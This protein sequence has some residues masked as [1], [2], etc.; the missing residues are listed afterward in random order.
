[1]QFKV[2][3]FDEVFSTNTLLKEGDYPIG[4][5]A[6][7]RTQTGGKGR[8]GKSFYSPPCGIYMSM[9]VGF[10]S[11][12]DKLFIPIK[13]AVS[14]HDVLSKYT[15]C[16]IKWPNDIV[17]GGKKLCGILSEGYNDKVIAGVGVNLNTPP[18]YFADNSLPYATSLYEQTGKSF[19]VKTVAHEILTAYSLQQSKDVILEKYKEN[20]LTIGRQITVLQGN[21][22]YDATAIGLTQNGELIILSDGKKLTLNSGEVSIRGSEY[23]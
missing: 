10:E 14:A 3:E 15:D 11:I 12:F 19:D 8:G 16:K 17:A 7:A 6:L 9:V 4:S 5:V 22:K 13:A 21:K 1:M 18:K 23:V 2:F 20:C